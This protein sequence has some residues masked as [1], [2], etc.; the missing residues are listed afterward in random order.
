ML[1]TFYVKL[2]SIKSSDNRGERIRKRF[3]KEEIGFGESNQGKEIFV[4]AIVYTKK[5]RGPSL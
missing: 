5:V 1:V 2:C 3:G 4:V